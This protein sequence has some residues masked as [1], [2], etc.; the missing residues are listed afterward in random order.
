MEVINRSE[1]FVQPACHV[2][3]A[4]AYARPFWYNF[5]D[6]QGLPLAWEIQAKGCFENYRK[7]L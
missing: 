1:T 4:A 6:N 3:H 5:P 7:E 2:I